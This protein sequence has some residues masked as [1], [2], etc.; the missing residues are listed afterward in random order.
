M[1]RTAELFREDSYRKDCEASVVHVNH[2]GGIVLDRTVFYPT[3]GGQPGDSGT[4][5]LAD[6]RQLHI[7]TTLYDKDTGDIVHVPAEPPEVAPGDT[8]SGEI[9]WHKR[10][11]HMRVHSCLHL[12]CALLP[13][14][15]TGGA[16]APTEGRLDF[17][18]PEAGL[19]KAALTD[20]L[21]ALIARDAP[22]GV[23]WISEDELDGR[24]ELVRTM[25]VRP[26]RGSGSVRLI[27][28]SGID[29]QP[30]GG[31]HVASTGEIGAAQ[32]TKIEKKGA[33]NRRVRIALV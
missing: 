26:P 17:D 12:L 8:L 33:Q 22:I 2:L 30:C 9:D 28:I 10:Y 20:E 23:S 32:V 29:L 11:G 14:P 19:D 6:G 18:I 16:I 31:T 3:G 24:P 21:N 15:V 5:S 25:A 27:E 1:G 13:Y 7:A 4:L